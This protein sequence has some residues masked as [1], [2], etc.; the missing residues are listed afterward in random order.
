MTIIII[1]ILRLLRNVGYEEIFQNLS[2][3]PIILITGSRIYKILYA[4]ESFHIILRNN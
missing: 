3:L 2:L 4:I 1:K